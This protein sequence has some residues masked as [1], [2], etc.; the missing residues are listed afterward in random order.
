MIRASRDK[1]LWHRTVANVVYD[2]T[3]P[4][5]KKKKK[6]QTSQNSIVTIPRKSGRMM[7]V[8]R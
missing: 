1:V 8:M 3:A 2:G 4:K 7:T 5:K 6:L